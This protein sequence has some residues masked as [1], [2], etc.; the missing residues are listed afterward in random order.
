MIQQVKL[1]NRM[2]SVSK[3]KKECLLLEKVRKVAKSRNRYKQ[4]PHLTQDI[5]HG[6]VTKTQ[7][8]ITNKSQKVSPY[9]AGDHKA[10]MNRHE[11]MTN[12]R[13]K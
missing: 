10:V 13:L 2:S 9:P 12:T 3:K 8:N 4:I 6:K 7:L 11:S 5:P 1:S